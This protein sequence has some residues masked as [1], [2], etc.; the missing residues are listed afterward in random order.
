VEPEI[1]H[2]FEA[3]GNFD[4]W[5]PN[6]P[7]KPTQLA[8]FAMYHPK[9]GKCCDTLFTA[10]FD[11]LEKAMYWGAKKE[12]EAV[13]KHKYMMASRVLWQHD[14]TPEQAV[15]T[16]YKQMEPQMDQAIRAWQGGFDLAPV[17][18]D[19]KAA[20]QPVDYSKVQG[21]AVDI[22]GPDGNVVSGFVPRDP[23]DSDDNPASDAKDGPK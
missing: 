8:V 19:P 16:A 9:K 6:Q 21:F 13:R 3:S 23:R 7:G 10:K 15:A 22:E 12:I 17:F 18:N 11:T 4:Q 14:L 2:N 1:V 20:L 5:P